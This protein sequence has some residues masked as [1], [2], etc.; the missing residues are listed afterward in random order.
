MFKIDDYSL[1]LVISEEFSPGKSSLEIAKLAISGRVDIIQMREKNK[2]R[3]ELL[4]LASG[5]SKLCKENGVTFIVNDD[6]QIAGEADA[7]GVHLGQTDKKKYSIAEARRILGKSG[8]IGVSTHSLAEFD[9]ANMDNDVDYIAYGPVFST[10]TK[11]YFLGTGSIKDALKIARKPVVFI[12]GIN[13][14]NVGDILVHGAKTIAVIRGICQAEDIAGRARSFKDRLVK[15]KEKKMTVRINGEYETIDKGSDLAGIVAGKKPF[16]D[17][18]VVEHNL[19][20]VAK[21]E[22]PGIILREND[23]IEIL[24]F[25][26]GGQYGRSIEDRR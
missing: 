21:E 24:S 13:L 7:D 19:R 2:P 5:L 23:Q 11:N 1:Y 4:K 9:E 15:E 8:I 26:G 16:L 3:D 25:M 10:E 20:I 22:W 17:T 18:V 6:P 12:G 14:S